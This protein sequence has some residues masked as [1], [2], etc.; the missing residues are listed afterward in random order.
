VCL[1]WEGRLID[2][3]GVQHDIPVDLNVKTIAGDRHMMLE[4]AV[5][6]LASKK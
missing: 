1:T 2:G 3:V 5:D 4:Q 6:E